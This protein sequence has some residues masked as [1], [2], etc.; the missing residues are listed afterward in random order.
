MTRVFMFPGQGSQSLGMGRDLFDQFPNETE[1]ASQILGYSIKEQCLN[2]PEERLNSTDVT[3]PALY[4]VNALH[5]LKAKQDGNT[6]TAVAG[7]SLGEYN[8]L[9]AAQVFDFETGLKLVQKRGALMANATGGGMAAVIGLS[10]DQ[11][12]ETLDKHNLDNIDLANYNSPQQIVL[13]GPKNAIEKAETPIKDAGAKLYVVLKVSGA[14]HSRYM[15]N[16]QKEFETFINTITFNT[17]SIPVIANVPAKPY[18]VQWTQS[19]QYL[20]QQGASEFIEIG[21]GKVLS[22]L[23]RK[24]KSHTVAASTN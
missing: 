18:S 8:A 2:G 19:I 24:I 21:P 5:Y 17:H 13:S 16:A 12:R 22:G 1:K 14:F 4:T 3:Q 9:F 6:P 7:H 23:L 20:L 11:I 15:G 10:A